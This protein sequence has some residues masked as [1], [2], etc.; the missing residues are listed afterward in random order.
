[1]REICKDA[2]DLICQFE[3]YRGTAYQ[4]SVGIWTI[5]FGTTSYPDG[6]R[7]RQGDSCTILEAREWLLHHMSDKAAKIAKAID[8]IGVKLNDN[9]FGALVSLCYNIGVGCLGEERSLGH[10]LRSKDRQAIATAFLVYTKA[11][12]KEL[13]GLV[14]RRAAERALFLKPVV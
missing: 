6:R 12:G 11:G 13:S 1:M 4:D 9:E 8:Q 5:G 14:R 2:L 3:G 10:A 7:V